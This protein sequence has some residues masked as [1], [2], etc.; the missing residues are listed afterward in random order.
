MILR[1]LVGVIAL[2]V[3]VCPVISNLLFG[4]FEHYDAYT[5]TVFVANMLCL[6]GVFVLMVTNKRSVIMSKIAL[7]TSFL[8]LGCFALVNIFYR[9]ASRLTADDLIIYSAIVIIAVIF[10]LLDFAK[11]FDEGRQIKAVELSDIKKELYSKLPQR[12]RKQ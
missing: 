5:L 12:W 2:L 1:N 9:I 3:L 6:A 11:A 4:V 8:W 7:A 10:V